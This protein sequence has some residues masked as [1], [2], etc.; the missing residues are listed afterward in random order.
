MTK[1][2]PPKLSV[3]ILKLDENAALPV[4]ANESDAGYDL[5]STQN[6]VIQSMTRSAISTSLAI[7]L[8]EGY[9]GRIAPRSG[10]AVNRGIDVLAG[11]IDSGYRGEIKVVLMNLGTEN[12][13]VRKGD[14]IAQ[15]ILEKCYS[16]K[17]REV[18]KEEFS[19]QKSERGKGGFGSSGN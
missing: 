2:D 19:S 17:F 15:I 7:I 1:K 10:L 4:K 3:K 6:M 11:V 9:Y 14:K 16:I 13:Y 12:F 5:F 18:T 8:P